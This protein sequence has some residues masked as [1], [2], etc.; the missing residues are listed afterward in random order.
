MIH[1]P[2]VFRRRLSCVAI[3]N[4]AN[5]QESDGGFAH[6]V[7]D[8]V[9]VIRWCMGKNGF[10]GPQHRSGWGHAFFCGD[11]G[12]KEIECQRQVDT[13]EEFGRSGGVGVRVWPW[14]QRLSD[15]TGRPPGDRRGTCPPC[16]TWRRDENK[17]MSMDL[18]GHFW[19]GHEMS[20]PSRD[21]RAAKR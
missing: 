9:E 14:I 21:V 12:E 4:E 18:L 20:G 3:N 15:P 6:P 19:R 8:W 2:A 17:W 11:T 1:P 7:E 13:G 5:K 10:K 16:L